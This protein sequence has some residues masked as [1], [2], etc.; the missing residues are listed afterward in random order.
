MAKVAPEEKVGRR[1]R[2]R[3]LQV[4]FA[5][6]QS[7]SM[8]KA[9]S[10]LGLTQPAVSDIVAGLEQMFGVR[11]FDRNPRG[12]V[13]TIYGQALLKRG[14]AAFDELRQGIKDIDF[15]SD[16]SAGELKI[17]CPAS[18]M[19]GSLSLAVE[20]FS[21]KYPRVVLQ[22]DEVT[23]PGSDFPSL[24]ERTHDLVVARIARPLADEE[25]LDVEIL[26]QD[27]LLI[28]ASVNSPWARRRRIDPAELV[29]EPWILTAS[30]ASVYVSVAEAFRARGIAV[31]KVSIVALSGLLRM[32]LVS[33][34]PFVTA[35]PR[36]LLEFNTVKLSLKILPVDLHIPGY[37]VAVLTLKNR[38]LNPLAGLFIEH[39]REVA[40]SIAAT[41]G[42]TNSRGAAPS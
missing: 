36:S 22:F 31:P 1:L 29:D 27:P 19:G 20:Y 14:R 4:F 18:V 13:A 33:R 35:I 6:V 32:F 9:A 15:L 12:V 17:G 5:V 10:K 26:F 30:D 11:L 37:P 23:S 7:G 3:D 24:R 16:P 21:R 41:D 34:G 40:R 2:F 8:A 25:D 28:A 38:V 39:V 42:R